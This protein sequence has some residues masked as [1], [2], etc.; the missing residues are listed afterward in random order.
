MAENDSCLNNQ[1][2]NVYGLNNGLLAYTAGEKSRGEEY[3]L[4]R[5]HARVARATCASLML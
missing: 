3:A 4:Q 2:L 5:H 1:R